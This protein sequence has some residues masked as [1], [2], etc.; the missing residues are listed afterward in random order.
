MRKQ[1]LKLLIRNII[2]ESVLNRLS[3]NN[4]D[5]VRVTKDKSLKRGLETP[6]GFVN[7]GEQIKGGGQVECEKC[8]E[9][10]DSLKYP[11][12]CPKCGADSSW[13]NTIYKEQTGTA[14]VAGYST[15]LAFVRKKKKRVKEK[16][17]PD[18]KYQDDM[19]NAPLK[20]MTSSGASFSGGPTIRVPAWGTKNKLGS[21]GAIA[22]TIGRKGHKTG[23]KIVKSI[24]EEEQ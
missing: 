23:F 19:E 22:A 8:K 16:T 15:P 5:A 10:F 20:E 24:S 1:H 7:V 21:P 17:L 6:M 3:V 11:K 2:R 14:A 12:Q 18:G 9:K 4:E 13:Y